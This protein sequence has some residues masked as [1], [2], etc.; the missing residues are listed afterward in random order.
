M[1]ISK[2]RSADKSIRMGVLIDELSRKD[3]IP[4]PM[5]AIQLESGLRML[6]KY[7]VFVSGTKICISPGDTDNAKGH[8]NAYAFL[9]DYLGIGVHPPF[10]LSAMESSYPM[11]WSCRKRSLG[12]RDL[13]RIAEKILLK[14]QLFVFS[15]HTKETS[16]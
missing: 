14:L 16:A 6:Q 10:L 4:G 7:Y 3:D 15:E 13:N 12:Y 1:D 8:Y 5:A 2:I 9:R 11:L